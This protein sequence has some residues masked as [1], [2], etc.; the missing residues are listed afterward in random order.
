[1]DAYLNSFTFL[2]TILWRWRAEPVML[3]VMPRV[4]RRGWWVRAEGN[5]GG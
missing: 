3:R 1:M 2:A 5:D 4:R